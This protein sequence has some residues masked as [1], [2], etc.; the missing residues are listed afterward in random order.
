[1]SPRDQ[2]D[3]DAGIQRYYG[4]VFDESA[5][6]TTR[7]AQGPLEFLRTQEIIRAHIPAGR[8]ADIGGGTGV[9]AVALSADG[10]EVELVEP[11]LRH[12]DAARAAGVSA[13]LGDARRLPFADAS[14]DGALLLGPLYHL[15]SAEDRLLALRE[16]LRIVHPGGVVLVAGLS[17]YIAFGAMSLGERIPDPLPPEWGELI[18]TGTPTGALRFPAGHFH[19][20]EELG[21]ELERAGF[22][23]LEVVG[24]EGPAGL[25]LETAA[26]FDADLRDA[27]LMLARAASCVPGIRDQS[28]HLV[29]IGRRPD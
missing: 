11:V 5:R 18:S 4:D 23:L 10:Y 28:A 19:T 14:F 20:A 12:V 2:Q 24:V 1:M 15:T 9:H 7:S 27:A 13:R 17:R 26:D 6:L 22:E 16:A 29:A 3:I 21:E 25:F 8:I